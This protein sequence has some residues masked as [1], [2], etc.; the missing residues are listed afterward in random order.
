MYKKVLC[1]CKVVVLLIKS[2]VFFDGLVAVRVVGYDPT[3]ATPMKT[4]LKNRLRVL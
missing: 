3:T 4:S 1:T 2:I